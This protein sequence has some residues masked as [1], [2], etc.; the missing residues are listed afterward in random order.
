M[1]N[2]S[3]LPEGLEISQ[4]TNLA[5]NTFIFWVNGDADRFRPSSGLGSKNIRIDKLDVKRIIEYS[6]TCDCNTLIFHDQRGTDRWY[7]ARKNFGAFIYAFAKG[8]RVLFSKKN[9]KPRKNLSFKEV[10]QNKYFLKN[11]LELAQE[12]FPGTAYHLIY[13]GHSFADSLTD[14]KRTFDMSI[15]DQDFGLKDLKAG[16]ENSQIQLET[17]TFAS[18]SMSNISFALELSNYAKYMIASQ[19]NINESGSTGFSFEFLNYIKDDLSSY[20]ISHLV[21][22]LIL[23]NFKKVEEKELFIRETPNTVIYLDHLNFYKTS[24]QSYLDAARINI[25]ESPSKYRNARIQINASNRYLD[26]RREAGADE[27]Q[28]EL[29]KKF[30]KVASFNLDYDLGV[31]AEIDGRED[32]LHILNTYSYSYDQSSASNKLGISMDLTY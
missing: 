10:H 17:I 1:A 32:I 4:N 8:E 5:K 19:V 23:Q 22:S 11:Y 13:R 29:I 18:C 16:L 25:K 20:E 30:L 12:V 15:Q 27:A 31:L 28:I 26:Q 24:L 21:G 7:T 14:N 9:K 6:K 3:F 2:S